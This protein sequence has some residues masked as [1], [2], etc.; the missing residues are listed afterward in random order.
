MALS[1]DEQRMLAEIEQRLAAEDPGLAARLS[2]FRRPSRVS[3]FRSARARVIGSLLTVA[4]VAM[5]SLMVYAIFPFR[6]GSRTPGHPVTTVSSTGTGQPKIGVGP[7]TKPAK[8]TAKSAS[9]SA[10][11]PAKSAAARAA[12]GSTVPPRA[13]SGSTVKRSSSSR[14]SAAAVHQADGSAGTTA[15][16]ASTSGQSP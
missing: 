15:Q 13:A 9:T 4:V 2:A 3:I 14:P 7:G 5:V 12:S 10:S 16:P 1:M 6:S 11:A 8:N